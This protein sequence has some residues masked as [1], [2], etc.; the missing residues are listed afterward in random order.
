MYKRLITSA[1]LIRPKSMY[2]YTKGWSYTIAFVSCLIPNKNCVYCRTI[3]SEALLFF[4]YSICGN[5]KIPLFSF[6]SFTHDKL[7]SHFSHILGNL[8][9]NWQ[10]FLLLI[11]SEPFGIFSVTANIILHREKN[12]HLVIVKIQQCRKMT[13]IRVY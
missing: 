13:H 11:R 7:M 2:S 6:D 12:T 10:S 9:N 4:Y 8:L 5:L 3:L 1:S